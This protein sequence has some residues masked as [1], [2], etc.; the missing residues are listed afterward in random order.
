MAKVIVKY[1]TSKEVIQEEIN[2]R[3]LDKYDQYSFSVVQSEVDSYLSK[4]YGWD[5]I[6]FRSISISVI[7]VI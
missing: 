4:K 2:V 1:D 7:E 6:Q 5:Y 3:H